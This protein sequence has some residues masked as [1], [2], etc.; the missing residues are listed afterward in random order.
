MDDPVQFKPYLVKADTM[1]IIRRITQIFGYVISHCYF[2][3]I[4]VT[5]DIYQGPLKATCIPFLTCYSCPLA[6]F[7]C[8]IGAFQH[9][10]VIR[11]LPFLDFAHVGIVALAVG[12]MACGWLCPLGLIQDLLYKIKSIK[13]KLYSFLFNIKYFSLFGLVMI[14]PYFTGVPWFSRSCPYGMLEAGL[15]WV[16]WNPVNPHTHVPPVGPDVVGLMFVVKFLILVVF[17]VLFVVSKRPFCRIACP[18]GVIFSF[19]NRISLVQI[20]ILNPEKCSH[21]CNL[22]LDVCP[23]E[24]KIADDPNSGECIRCL[25]CMKCRKVKVGIGNI[26]ESPSKPKPVDENPG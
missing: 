20:E 1:Q 7:S 5:K 16:L 23:M 6:V 12:R 18:L 11:K 14:I 24:I 15:P 25:K 17:L 19:F 10:A 13:I 22:C 3:S 2:K 26:F 8:P 9:Y 21:K 4:F